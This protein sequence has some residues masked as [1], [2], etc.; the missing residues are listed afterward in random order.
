MSAVIAPATGKFEALLPVLI[1]GAGAAGLCAALANRAG[2]P[3]IDCDLRDLI[4]RMSRENPLWGAPR[5]HGELLMLG[6]DVA[7]STVSK[8]MVRRIAVLE[9]LS[10][11][12]R[13]CDRFHR[14]VRGS[15]NEI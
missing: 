5:I 7:Q 10:S 1:I 2:R 6:F 4:Q 3:N 9:D 13:R 8:Y 15:N 12:P 14:Y 11:E